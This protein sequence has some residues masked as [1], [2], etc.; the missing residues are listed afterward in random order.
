MAGIQKLGEEREGGGRYKR[1]GSRRKSGKLCK[2]HCFIFHI[3]QILK[4]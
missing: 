1:L 4:E 3:N 2:N